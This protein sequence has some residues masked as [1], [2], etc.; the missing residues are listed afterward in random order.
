MIKGWVEKL[1]DQRKLN[2]EH[3]SCTPDT[4]LATGKEH[5]NGKICNEING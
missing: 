4:G 5:S 2:K 1:Q 3:K